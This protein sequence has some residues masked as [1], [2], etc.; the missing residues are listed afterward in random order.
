MSMLLLHFKSQRKQEAFQ[1]A[2]LALL[3]YAGLRFQIP[4]ETR[5]LSNNNNEV[6]LWAQMKFQ[7]PTETRGLSNGSTRRQSVCSRN[8][9]NPNGN[10]RPFKPLLSATRLV[11][12]KD[13]KSQRKQEAFQTMTRAIV[14][15]FDA[16]FQIPTETR[17]L[18]NLNTMKDMT[19]YSQ[20]QIPTETIGLSNN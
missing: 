10:K 1:T 8:I 11:W 3:Y 2:I 9:S 18:S 17:G 6:A 7:I 5:G 12:S 13:F 19:F 20:F 16:L 15:T 14:R 4:T